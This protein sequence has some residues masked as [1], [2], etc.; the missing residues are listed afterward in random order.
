MMLSIMMNNIMS[1]QVLVDGIFYNLNS[2]GTCSTTED[3][4]HNH[5]IYKNISVL[6][7]PANIKYG[8]KSYRVT[9]IGKE[10]F[11]DLRSLRVVKIPNSITNIESRAFAQ[12]FY[13]E[14][15]NIPNSVLS[16]GDGA[17]CQ[18][19][20]LTE[21]KIPASVA[22]IGNDAFYHCNSLTDVVVDDENEY[23][24]SQEGVLFN[25]EMTKLVYL[26][27]GNERTSY[28]I[29]NTV[30]TIGFAAV[31]NCWNLTSITIPSSVTK[32][33]DDA[34]GQ[35]GDIQELNLPES[36]VSIGEWAFEYWE[37]ITTLKL[38]N[39]LKHLGF[40]A[41]SECDALE[42]IIIPESL[43]SI[44]EYIFSECYN[45]K[46]IYYNTQKPVETYINIFEDNIY[47]NAT[48]YV[49]ESSLEAIKKTEPWCLFNKIETYDFSQ[50]DISN[51][52]NESKTVEIARYDLH[53]KQV[54]KEYKGV[55]IIEYSNGS[56][57][58]TI[59]K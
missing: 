9:A 52:D 48:L 1:A 8:G 29:P 47:T 30:K 2:D 23:Y 14:K 33:E 58:K 40:C 32:I 38:P 5:G 25:K 56:K 54:S 4:E 18:C 11:H 37:L 21:I 46:S 31:T 12:C 16:I 34:F 17:F 50:S 55:I 24:T 44:D 51:I 15:I 20:P 53:G 10:S 39:K 3:A 19:W 42:I 49:N 43:S 27:M 59:A 45:V 41:F 7:I 36:I 57:C 28:D 6:D 13:L 26:P 35:S 22:Y